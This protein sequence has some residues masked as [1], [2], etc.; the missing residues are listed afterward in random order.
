V[1]S[2]E[3][4]Q[5]VLLCTSPLQVVL[6]R[7]AADYMSERDGI[8][9]TLSVITTHPTIPTEINSGWPVLIR[10]IREV[11][12]ALDCEKVVDCSDIYLSIFDRKLDTVSKTR[13]G[14]FR[15]LNRIQ[16]LVVRY[17]YSSTKVQPRI[18]DEIGTVDEIYLRKG[19]THIEVVLLR[20]MGY[21]GNIYGIEDGIGDYDTAYWRTGLSS[22]YEIQH[23]L[24]HNIKKWLRFLLS[25][26]LSSSVNISKTIFL[27]SKVEFRER[28]SVLPNGRD[29]VIRE[30][31]YC[32]IERLRKHVPVKN[33]MK[34]LI[35]GSIISGPSKYRPSVTFTMEQEV[36]MY[37]ACIKK[38]KQMH[39]V[40][41]N[42]IWYKHHP[43]TKQDIYLYKKK[44]LDCQ[45]YDFYDLPIAET[46][47]ANPGLVAV[48]S[49]GSTSLLFAKELF[50]KSSYFIDLTDDKTVH[51]RMF[52]Q[53]KRV[54][55]EYGI[56]VLSWV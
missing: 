35:V 54:A 24:K 27:D 45:M 32:N 44:Y 42:E 16:C 4:Y 31:F 49:V 53:C 26:I 18:A 25:L 56:T 40:S 13:F 36:N 3:V 41:G 17:L 5:T 43:R 19:A 11:A 55:E 22:L 6:A 48:Y 37:N 9:R 29:T 34:V 30:H 12:E 7:S 38:I 2:S 15:A 50:N 1:G 47:I 39:E 51:P 20:L 8:R 52:Q 33:T 28:F 14:L 46:D 10:P 21:S 23:A